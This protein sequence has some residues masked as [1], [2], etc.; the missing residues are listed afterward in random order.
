MLIR[1]LNL[2]MIPGGRGKPVPRACLVTAL[3]ALLGGCT[4]PDT[5]HTSYPTLVQLTP[6]Q[7]EHTL[8]LTNVFLNAITNAEGALDQHSQ[9]T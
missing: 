3:L 9:H 8:S 4:T 6:Q 2:S 7:G 5:T 1:R